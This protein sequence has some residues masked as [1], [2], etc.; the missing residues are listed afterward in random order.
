MIGQNGQK[1]A[2]EHKRQQERELGQAAREEGRHH[3]VDQSG[4]DAGQAKQVGLVLPAEV[5]DA[6]K[7]GDLRPPPG[8][9]STFSSTSS[10]R[11]MRTSFVLERRELTSMSRVPVAKGPRA[12]SSRARPLRKLG[13]RAFWDVVTV[14]RFCS[15]RCK[16]A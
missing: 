2:Q 3:S 1:L 13:R 10:K 5:A 12:A 11:I 6:R 16:T 4:Q 15:T 9:P 8:K 14:W 7:E